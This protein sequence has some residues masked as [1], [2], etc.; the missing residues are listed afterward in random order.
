M[1]NEKAFGPPDPRPQ[2]LAEIRTVNYHLH[3]K[4]EYVARCFELKV[5]FHPIFYYSI[6]RSTETV[7]DTIEIRIT[8]TIEPGRI[9]PTNGDVL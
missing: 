9:Q 1:M 5:S 7:T 6:T 4:G 3:G 2:S 8:A